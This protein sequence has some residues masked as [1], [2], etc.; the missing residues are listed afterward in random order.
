MRFIDFKKYFANQLVFDQKQVKLIEPNFDA[1]I[2][3]DWQKKNYIK[4][5]RKSYY[6][7][8]DLRIDDPTLY[9]ISNQIYEPSYI[10]FEL[11]LSIYGL[12]PETVYGITAASSRKTA[13]FNTCLGNFYYK[14]L[15]PVLMFGYRIDTVNNIGY[16]IAKLEKAVLDYC[17][18]YA[19]IQSQSEFDDIRFNYHYFLEQ[20]EQDILLKYLDQYSN[21]SLERRIR[22]LLRIA[23]NA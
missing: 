19:D 23:K 5:I 22:N 16:K 21:K 20:V 18:I 8:S 15:K 4:K 2:L 14:H 13:R 10:S 17:Y 11:A 7:F 12:I 9:H 6:I 1:N 3:S